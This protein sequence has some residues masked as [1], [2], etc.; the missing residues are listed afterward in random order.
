MV[1]DKDQGRRPA[2]VSGGLTGTPGS[3]G[4]CEPTPAVR[5]V[6]P[7]DRRPLALVSS[8][9]AAAKFHMPGLQLA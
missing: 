8:G 9:L 2:S 1:H 6:L 7:T 5:V 4:A 3:E